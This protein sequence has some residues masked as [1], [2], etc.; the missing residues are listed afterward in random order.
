MELL[1]TVLTLC[2]PLNKSSRPS[3]PE[4]PKAS[5]IVLPFTSA[6]QEN[7]MVLKLEGRGFRVERFADQQLSTNK[8]IPLRFLVPWINDVEIWV[9]RR[10]LLKQK[11]NKKGGE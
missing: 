1:S 2:D 9:P 3:L 8:F 10:K 5:K 11:A 6:N 7:K 4:P